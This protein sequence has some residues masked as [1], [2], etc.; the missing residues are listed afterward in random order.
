M[1]W[2]VTADAKTGNAKT[3]NKVKRV[4]YAIDNNLTHPVRVYAKISSIEEITPG[5]MYDAG[6]TNVEEIYK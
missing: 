5:R 2:I 3:P 4:V 1:P 6:Y